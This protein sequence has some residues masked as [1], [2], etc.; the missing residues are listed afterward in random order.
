[1]QV[2]LIDTDGT[3]LG[4][5]PVTEALLM[6]R[7]KGLDL[8]EIAPMAA[9]PVC[10]ILDHSKYLYEK[11]RQAREARKKQKAGL[12]KEVRLSPVIGAHDL[13]VKLKHASEFLRQNDKVRITVVF[14]GRQNQ[15]KELGSTLLA[16]VR[17]RLGEVA[18]AEGSV[19]LD[20]NR[21]FLMLI[22][23]H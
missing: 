14:R 1:M 7:S 10:K 23:K 22:P 2:R 8:I 20:R 21:M 13:D 19:T 17:E 5:R 11:E 15:H 4:I 18:I 3:Q 6:A 9:P 12:L 16:S